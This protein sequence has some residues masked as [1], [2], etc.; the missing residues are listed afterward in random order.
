[1]GAIL[2][3][4]LSD[5][6]LHDV[7]DWGA[8]REI[9]IVFQ[10]EAKNPWKSSELQR[11]LLFDQQSFFAQ[12]S[13][14]SRASFF[15]SNVFSTD[16]QTELHLP[17]GVQSFFVSRKELERTKPT[18]FQTRFPNNSGYFVVSHA[19][20]N[21]SKTEALLYIDHFCSGLCGG[22]TYVLMHK[23]NGM[24]RIVDQHSTWVS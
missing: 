22:G 14:T 18:D 2:S 9:Q 23:V 15:V 19:G 5:E 17:R 24:W 8:G 12:S 4:L 21:L 10:R 11:S 6:V 16:I 13:R 3:A 1:M 7:Q 20:L